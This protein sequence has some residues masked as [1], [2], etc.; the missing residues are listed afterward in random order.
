MIK[1]RWIKDTYD[2][3]LYINYELNL[4]IYYF[5][6]YLLNILLIMLKIIRYQI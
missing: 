1:S 5:E 2:I 3:I 6:K 4:L